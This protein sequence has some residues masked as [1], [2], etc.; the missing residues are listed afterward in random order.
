VLKQR[1]PE[2]KLG[3]IRNIVIDGVSGTARGTSRVIGHPDRPVENLTV[4]NLDVRQ[5]AENAKDKRATDA[6][7]F[8]RVAGLQLEKVSIR[9]DDTQPEPQWKSAVS[10]KRVRNF[11]INGLRARQGLIKGAAPAVYFEAVED[12]WVRG[13]QAE[14]DTG[15]L[16][17]T[18]GDVK[19]VRFSANDA[20]HA[21]K[22]F[23]GFSPTLKGF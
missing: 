13:V 20:R 17:G 5:L 8:D 16:F 4:R 7:Q 3:A 21:G 12:G 1:T 11:E 14:A 23:D 22:E 19:G 9:W 15:V 2:S 6:M 18:G 10:L